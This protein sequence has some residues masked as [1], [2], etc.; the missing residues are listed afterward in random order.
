MNSLLGVG[1]YSVQEAAAITGI[2]ARKIRRWLFQ[3]RN[4]EFNG[5]WKTELSGLDMSDNL[6]FHDLLELRFV[7]AFRNHGV[8]FQ[9]IRVAAL[10]AQELIG[11]K[12]PFTC[13]K[14]L[15]DGQSIFAQ[16]LEETGDECLMDLV[17]KQY[18]FKQVIS[19][20]LYAGIEYNDNNLAS[21]W[22][23]TRSRKIVLDPTR[24]FG[25]PILTDFG[26]TTETLFAAWKAEDK[27]YRI[28]A[29]T[30]EIPLDQVKAAIGFEQR[31]ASNEVLH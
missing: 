10:H 31:I 30:Y 23:P 15:T 6:S 4:N 13:K 5:L 25:K 9:A 28:V 27:N 26:I 8:S 18:V 11:S 21:R 7:N 16:T 29:D 22:Y 24:S 12:Y 19:D 14:F 17:K 20:S 3:Y 2:E 1:I